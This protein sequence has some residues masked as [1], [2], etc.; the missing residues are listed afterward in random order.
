MQVKLK[1]LVAA[2]LISLF[3]TLEIMGN[4]AL[5]KEY[6]ITSPQLLI[7]SILLFTI[8]FLGVI[9][10]SRSSYRYR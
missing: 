10:A 5:F 7:L 3:A 1:I 6:V 9:I 2:F 4:I 8:Y